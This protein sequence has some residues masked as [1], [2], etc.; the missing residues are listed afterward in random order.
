MPHA[1]LAAELDADMSVLARQGT[2][3]PAATNTIAAALD[4]GLPALIHNMQ[5]K[6]LCIHVQHMQ[7]RSFRK[8]GSTLRLLATDGPP[9]LGTRM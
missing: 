8:K 2:C 9:M 3:V 1:A 6:V 5:H 4:S 7:A